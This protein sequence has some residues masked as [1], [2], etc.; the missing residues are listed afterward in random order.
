MV[1]FNAKVRSRQSK[2]EHPSGPHFLWTSA[3]NGGKGSPL[4]PAPFSH[5]HTRP[6]IRHLFHIS[7]CKILIH[8]ITK[9][10][11]WQ[12]QGHHFTPQYDTVQ[13]V[14]DMQSYMNPRSCT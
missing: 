1:K 12:G 5:V 2:A 11:V 10:K 8:T 6:L 3:D 14:I 9:E 7:C 13:L 4:Q